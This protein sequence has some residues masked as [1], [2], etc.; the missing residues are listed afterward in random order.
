VYV[1][2]GSYG[3]PANARRVADA[4][5]KARLGQVQV[6]TATVNGRRVTRVRLGPF[7]DTAEAAR[8]ADEVR[9][10]GLGNPRVA[11]D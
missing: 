3:D 4:L 8:R 5:G 7:P 11:T 1:Q 2:V 10:R 6:L 9:R